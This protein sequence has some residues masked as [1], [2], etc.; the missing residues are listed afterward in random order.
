LAEILSSRN[1]KPSEGNSE[2][3]S[4][5][6]RSV[7]GKLTPVPI[8]NEDMLMVSRLQI[9]YFLISESYRNK[10][11]KVKIKIRN[12]KDVKEKKDQEC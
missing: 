7:S 3:N 5:K 10:N 4:W 2:A 1:R 12:P 8:F 6:N 11:S 9:H